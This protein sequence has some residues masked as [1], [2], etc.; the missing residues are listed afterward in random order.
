MFGEIVINVWYTE[1]IIRGHFT[2]SGLSADIRVKG[3]KV[4][5]LLSLRL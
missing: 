5:S 2:N 1:E 3:V 4:L